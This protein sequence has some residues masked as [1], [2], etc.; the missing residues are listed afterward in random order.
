MLSR[1]ATE[2]NLDAEH[3]ICTYCDSKLKLRFAENWDEDLGGV[4]GL[5]WFEEIN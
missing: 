1:H 4:Y 2:E 3:F 5:F